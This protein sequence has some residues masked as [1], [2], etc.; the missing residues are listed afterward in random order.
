MSQVKFWEILI[1]NSIDK[2]NQCIFEWDFLGNDNNESNCI[3]GKDIYNVYT[4]I[5]KLNN[6]QLNIGSKCIK[7]FMGENEDLNDQI[8]NIEK[9]KKYVNKYN[10]YE[11]INKK[12]PN[13]IAFNNLYKINQNYIN[14]LK[15]ITLKDKEL[16]KLIKYVKYYEYLKNN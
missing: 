10:L 3:C 12:Y 5:N 14:F 6:I 9:Y 4:V 1:L 13:G 16:K 8:N 2:T 11:L 15:S 7:K